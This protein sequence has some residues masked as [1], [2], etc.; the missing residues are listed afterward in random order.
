LPIL[1]ACLLLNI[2]I[3]S[4]NVNRLMMVF[5]KRLKIFSLLS[6]TFEGFSKN[7]PLRMAGATA[8]FT[9]F[10]LPAVL[11]ILIQIFG[12]FLSPRFMTRQLFH[13]L[14]EV[15]GRNTA[16]E[17]HRTLFNVHNLFRNG[18]EAALGFLFL[19]FVA[20]T[21][22]KVIKDSLNQLWNI[23]T[24]RHTGIKI[25]LLNRAK[26]FMI[27]MI[28]GILFLIVLLA[29]GGLDL[30]RQTSTDASP[31]YQMLGKVIIRQFISIILISILFLVLFKFL[32][33]GKPS[34]KT[35]IAGAIFTGLLFTCGKLLLKWLLTYSNMQTVYGASTS[36]VLLLLF[37]FYSSF[38]FYFGA[39][40]T[41]VWA[42]FHNK[43]IQPSKNAERFEWQRINV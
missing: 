21:L 15:I 25:S 3:F 2:L 24:I 9:T 13:N 34:L 8:F 43:P 32:P 22:L 28:A 35:L 4:L 23:R 10:A 26:S 18:Y 16:G 27:I 5:Y 12:L 17:L 14:G 7:D 37:V 1:E 19:I 31:G 11:I 40:F 30:I 33:D 38:I 20:T 42:E 29:E 6:K 36:S 39:C 41:R